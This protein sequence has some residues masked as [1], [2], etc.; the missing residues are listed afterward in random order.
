MLEGD[1]LKDALYGFR[2]VVEMEPE[3]GEWW[4]PGLWGGGCALARGLASGG[5]AG[6]QLQFLRVE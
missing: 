6:G 2:Q 1:D 4:A 3:K 5:V